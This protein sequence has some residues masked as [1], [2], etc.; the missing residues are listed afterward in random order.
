MPHSPLPLTPTPHHSWPTAHSIWPS[1]SPWSDPR[2]QGSSLSYP[3]FP[4]LSFLQAIL[5]AQKTQPQPVYRTP[6]H[7]Q[8]MSKERTGPSKSGLM[9]PQPSFGIAHPCPRCQRTPLVPPLT[10]PHKPRGGVP[11]WCLSPQEK[12]GLSTAGTIARSLLHTQRLACRQKAPSMPTT[13]TA[14][15]LPARTPEWLAFHT[16]E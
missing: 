13:V 2:E 7:T 15:F 1:F 4:H 6:P 14:L 9:S 3:P 12:A 16:E 11:G 5:T 8:I 10:A